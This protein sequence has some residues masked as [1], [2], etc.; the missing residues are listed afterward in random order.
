VHR[1]IPRYRTDRGLLHSFTPEVITVLPSVQDG[2]THWFD[3]AGYLL[4]T[5]DSPGGDDDTLAQR[6]Y[7]L[8]PKESV[9]R[10][11]R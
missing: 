10:V 7:A 1:R 9:I 5:S 3:G 11:L 2:E 8:Y 4:A 6:D